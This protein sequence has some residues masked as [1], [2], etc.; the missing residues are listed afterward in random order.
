MVKGSKKRLRDHLN[1]GMKV[2]KILKLQPRTKSL[3]HSRSAS[4][5]KLITYNTITA[6]SDFADLA[7]REQ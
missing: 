7:M 6:S 4:D 5:L 2:G 3:A 1:V